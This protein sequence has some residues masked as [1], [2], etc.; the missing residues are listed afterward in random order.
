M[1]LT[2]NYDEEKYLDMEVLPESQLLA[3]ILKDNLEMAH[4]NF[5]AYYHEIINQIRPSNSDIFFI[6]KSGLQKF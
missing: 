2:F 4:E 6:D 1:E 5:L 3:W